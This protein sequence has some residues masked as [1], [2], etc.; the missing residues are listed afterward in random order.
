MPAKAHPCVEGR[1]VAVEFLVQGRQLGRLGT[2]PQSGTADAEGALHARRAA[3]P[4]AG[5][6]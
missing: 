3:P 5:V 2:N 6:H 1:Q 4:Q